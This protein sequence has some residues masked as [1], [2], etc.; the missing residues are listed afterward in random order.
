MAPVGADGAHRVLD[1]V[2][3][4]ALGGEASGPLKQL[5]GL[6]DAAEAFAAEVGAAGNG[7]VGAGREE[8]SEEHG[9]VGWQ[10]LAHVDADADDVALAGFAGRVLQVDAVA[11]V[12]SIGPRLDERSGEVEAADDDGGRHEGELVWRLVELGGG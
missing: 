7:G 2:G 10:L 1:E 9:A 11:E 3:S 5:Q 12:A 4:L 8:G 6:D